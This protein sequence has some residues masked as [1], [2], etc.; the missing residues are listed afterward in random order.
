MALGEQIAFNRKLKSMT[1][2]MLANRLSVSNQAVSKW[3]SNQCCP[4]IQLLPQLADI[5]EI[6]IDELFGRKDG[7][8]NQNGNENND[9]TDN[10]IKNATFPWADDN[11][12]RVVLFQGHTI[13]EYPEVDKIQNMYF[14]YQGEA[15]NIESHI[16]VKCGNVQGNVN[17]GVSIECKDVAGNVT[18]GTGIK[19]EDVE[20]NINAGTDVNCGDVEGSINA[21][22]NVVCADVGGNVNAGMNVTCADVEGNVSARQNVSCE[23]IEGDV[24]AKEVIYNGE[25]EGEISIE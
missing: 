7:S 14:E 21:G 6:S 4:D 15:L 10:V 20:G 24:K 19:C 23:S 5:F 17:A 2:E 3:E 8:K 13:C 11:T 18:S 9:K 22:I 25:V 12:L 1:Q 16:S